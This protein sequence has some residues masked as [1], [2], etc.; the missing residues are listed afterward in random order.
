MEYTRSIM[1]DQSI[2]I[3]LVSILFWLGICSKDVAVDILLRLGDRFDNE[4]LF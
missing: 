2:C 4:C 1:N 3:D